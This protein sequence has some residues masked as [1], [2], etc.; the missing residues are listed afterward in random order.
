MSSCRFSALIASCVVRDSVYCELISRS[1]SL[2]SF[3]FPGAYG[4]TIHFLLARAGIY[5][6]A[7]VRYA[8]MVFLDSLAMEDICLFHVCSGWGLGVS[9]VTE[10]Y[11][12]F[13]SVFTEDW[14]S[15]YSNATSIL[16][17]R[18]VS[19]DV[20]PRYLRNFGGS[21][22]HWRKLF[23][24]SRL[25][26]NGQHQRTLC[27][28]ATIRPQVLKRI[29]KKLHSERKTLW[30]VKATYPQMKLKTEPYL[31]LI[32]FRRVQN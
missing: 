14:E 27:R 15:F 20:S 12:E 24:V 10:C 30:F 18:E 25:E 7:N 32:H 11:T 21:A 22:I 13:K 23:A 2:V 17:G 3:V 9:C 8:F 26:K 6:G 19:G 4:D 29:G 16:H 1:C 31:V 28:Y 5:V